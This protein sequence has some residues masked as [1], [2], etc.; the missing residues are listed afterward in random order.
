VIKKRKMERQIR[1][2]RNEWKKK[3]KERWKVE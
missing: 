1:K 3:G 2:A